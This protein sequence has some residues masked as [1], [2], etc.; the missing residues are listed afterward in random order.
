MAPQKW[1]QTLRR[2]IKDNHGNGWN[3]IA[4]SGKCKLTRRFEDGTKSAKVL[5]I[6][7]KA[8]NSVAILNAVTRVREL[9]ETRNVS[10]AE[11][12]RLDTEALAVPE[13]HNGTADQAWAAVVDEYLK[14]KKGCASTTLAD[15]KLRLNR[16]V[17]SLDSKPKPRDS[18]ALLKRYAE[19]HLPRC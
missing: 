2:Q 17:V 19:L 16:V 5:P 1:E 18:R 9:V 13:E 11:A 12:V 7:W 3:V 15:L 8:T 14:T 6:E 10:V 4:Q